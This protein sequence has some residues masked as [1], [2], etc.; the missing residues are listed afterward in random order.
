MG[1]KAII[2]VI[3]FSLIFAGYAGIAAL[4]QVQTDLAQHAERIDHAFYANK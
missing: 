3:I 2:G 1:V 4:K